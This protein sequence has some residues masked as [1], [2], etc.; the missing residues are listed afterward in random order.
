MLRQG[1]IQVD[2]DEQ[3]IVATRCIAN[4]YMNVTRM[5]NTNTVSQMSFRI[6][7]ETDQGYQLQIIDHIANTYIWSQM[8]N[9]INA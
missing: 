6:A 5:K 4:K 1:Q 7:L 8:T 9:K 3:I 2:S